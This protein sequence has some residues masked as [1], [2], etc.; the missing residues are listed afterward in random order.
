MKLKVVNPLLWETLVARRL[1][2]VSA[3]G[4]ARAVANLKERE[5]VREVM[6]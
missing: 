2:V 1:F 6:T 3:G 4:I 5:R